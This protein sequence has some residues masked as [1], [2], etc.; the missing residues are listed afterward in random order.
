MFAARQ[1]CVSYPCTTRDRKLV[2]WNLEHRGRRKYR[3]NQRLAS[4]AQRREYPFRALT[5]LAAAF[6]ARFA[7]V[8]ARI[9]SAGSGKAQYISFF[10][11]ESSLFIYIRY[12]NIFII[13]KLN[14]YL[15]FILLI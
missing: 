13:C 5:G 12:S 15:L 8:F 1:V 9:F 3:R 7:T 11:E 10:N 14:D 2:Q 4:I 6:F